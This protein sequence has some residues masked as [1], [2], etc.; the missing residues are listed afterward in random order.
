VRGTDGILDIIEAAQA[1]A[2]DERGWPLM[3]QKLARMFGAAAATLEDFNKKPFGLQYLRI[4]GL[5]P[6]AETAYLSHY[7]HNNPRAAYAFRH[8]SEK[9]LYDHVLIDE[10]TMDRDAYYTKYLNALDLRYF[11][12]GQILNT[13]GS[14][15]IVSIQRTR[16]QGHVE[17]SDV[18]RMRRLLPHL[19]LAYDM[20]TRLRHA[21]TAVRSLEAAFEW[22]S[23]GVALLRADGTI[24]YSNGVFQEMIRRNDGIRSRKGTIEFAA[25]TAKTLLDGAVDDGA[26]LRAGDIGRTVP[27][28][29]LVQRAS[30][31]PPYVV[32]VRPLAESATTPS[33]AV[34]IVFVRGPT[35]RD[36][37]AAALLRSIFGLTEAEAGV[38]QALQSGITLGQYSHSRKV[39]LNTVYTHLRRI[40]EKLGCHRT[41]EL[42]RKLNDVQIPLRAHGSPPI[43]LRPK[44]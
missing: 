44:S 23:D 34:A 26:R 6:M 35:E 4:A 41:A 30:D 20:S 19:N 32:S 43:R 12:S 16:R 40:K 27:T 22:L 9:V 29:F 25:R 11:M 2:L 17:R 39:S 13:P 42:I 7:Q 37:A 21:V 38:A 33:G 5:P 14:Q 18:E 3:L 36:A 15:A 1:A 28:D 10:R 8:L 24:A 31:A